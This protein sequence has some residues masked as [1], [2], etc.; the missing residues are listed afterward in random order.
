ME[1]GAPVV[2]A[3]TSAP[4]CEL[5]LR[6]RWQAAAEPI[7]ISKGVVVSDVDHGG[8][9][10]AV[11]RAPGTA[12]LAPVCTGNVLP[13][14]AVLALRVFRRHKHNRARSEDFFTPIGVDLGIDRTLGQSH[15]A[16]CFD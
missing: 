13:P 3:V 7:R 15:I 12:G 16:R 2:F 11:D 6:F 9:F 10:L 8:I 14:S 5:P 1:S 4:R